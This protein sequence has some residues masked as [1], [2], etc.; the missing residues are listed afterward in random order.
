MRFNLKTPCLEPSIQSSAVAAA[1][2]SLALMLAPSQLS[3]LAGAHWV[4]EANGGGRQSS[5]L[6]KIYSVVRTAMAGAEDDAVWGVAKTVQ[7]ES[8]R[9]SLD[10]F[11]VLAVI[12]VES[13]FR[14]AAEAED[15]ARGL[16][17]IQPESA[18]LI[19][20]KR[21]S[22][23][24]TDKHIDADD[25]DLDNP[26]V[27]IKLGVFYLNSLQRI[28]RDQ[29]LALTAYNRGPARVQSLLLEEGEVPLEYAQKVL[30][31]Y[32]SY[33]KNGRRPG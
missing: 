19:A 1:L 31:T 21:K 16:M 9:H 3:K 29:K 10:P 18:K 7:R 8:Q 15:G 12:K 5:E 23:Y 24:R 33:R 30:S 20:Q 26:I 27:N 25:P 6:L 17:Q 11:L 22:L 14:H 2:L 13:D 32:E 4:E 28:F